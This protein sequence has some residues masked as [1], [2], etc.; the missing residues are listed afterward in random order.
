M[1][2]GSLSPL[3]AV[4]L[5][6]VPVA[7]A[8]VI[9]W[10]WLGTP[11]E[12]PDQPLGPSQKLYCVSYAPFRGQQTPLDK[13]MRV[14]PSQI[15]EDLKQLSR[16]TD[17]VRTYSTD[18]GLDRIAE[19]AARYNLKVIQGLWLGREATRN[20][21]EI[22]T[23]VGIAKR[24]PNVLR[25]IVVGNEVLLRGEM[26]ASDLANTIRTVKAQVQ[27]PVTY[28]DVWEFWL[29]FREAYDAVDF[30]TIHVL[31]YWEDFPIPAGQAAEHVDNIRRKI[32]EAFPN[33]EILIGEVGW[34]SAGRMREGALPSP[35]NQAQ[36]LTDVLAL[37]RRENF[38]VN[39]IEAFDQPWKEQLE[40]TVGG[41]W[42]LLDGKTRDFK[43]EW[44]VPV[45]NHPDWLR[46]A[47]GGIVLAGLIF[48]AGL[49]A[50]RGR[51][52]AG[53]ISVPTWIGLAFMAFGPGMVVGWAIENVP[54][55]SLG[56][57]GWLRSLALV[58]L[59]VAAPL[60]AAAA[61]TRGVPTPGFAQVL[62][63][64][65]ER[66]ADPLMMGLGLVYVL[67]SLMAIQVALGLVFDP[68]YR[69]FP[70]TPLTAA[71]IPFVVL[72]LFGP[73]SLGERGIAEL[74]SAITLG[75]CAIYIVLNEGFD[76]W[77][78]LWLA[79][80]LAALSATLARSRDAQ[81]LK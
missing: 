12:M 6:I 41:H 61:L 65:G 47:C 51:G 15:D 78:G 29:R 53:K 76:N 50:R 68:R 19:I 33:K 2:R 22:E 45:S 24:F 44:G 62:A 49:A 26:S 28:A 10:S 73:R 5:L 21:R 36:V 69:D 9:C 23:V 32:A 66:P 46:Q 67:V 38:H 57:G 72:T 81:G 8:I 16:L 14:D 64:A 70:F 4:G 13:T 30:I 59:G 35:A 37:A 31:P 79:A 56:V 80:T 48:G 1:F 63:R 11:I 58:A 18:L 42:G 71:I 20:R 17:C 54:I 27:V 7:A 25:A 77:Q 34:P 3:Q 43:F 39:V 55:E 40:G 60:L 75:G 52:G 74:V